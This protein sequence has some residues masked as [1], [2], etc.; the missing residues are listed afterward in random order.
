M[1]V[2]AV[3]F[4]SLLGGEFILRLFGIGIPAFRVA[5]GLLILLMG[6][7]MLRA[8]PDRSRQTPEERTESYG[9]ESV[10]VVPLAIPLLSGP[11]AISAIIVYSH[12]K[13]SCWQHYILVSLAIGT[14]T[15]IVLATLWMAPKIASMLGKTGMNVITRIMGLIIFSIAV[16]FI[17][18]GLTEL[19]PILGRSV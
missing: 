17:A 7:S 9:K 2:S 18:K 15:L 4:A 12:E 19:F 5:G 14:V 8:S 3:L 13:C 16:E 6:V 1:A 10:A 11:G